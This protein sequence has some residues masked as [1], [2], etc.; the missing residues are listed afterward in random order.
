MKYGITLPYAEGSM[1]REEV[2]AFVRAADDHGFNSLWIPE[3]WTFDA[4]LLLTS[5]IE[6][7]SNMQL[8]TGIV[9]VYSRTPALLGQSA[10]TLDALSGGRAVLGL[11]A[12]GPQVVSGWHGMAYDRPVG[13]TREAVEIVRKVIARE[14]LVHDGDIFQLKMGL[15]IIN[16]PIR[17]ELPIVIASMGPNNVAMTAEVA[18]GWM[19]V[20]FSPSR[21]DDVWGEPLAEGKA[22]RHE[23]LG[24]LEVLPALPVAIIES[25]EERAIARMMAKAGLALY[26]GGMGSRKSNF[27][28]DLVCRY[29]YD[30]EAKVIQDLYLTGKAKEAMAEVPDALVDELTIIGDESEV[31]E[32]VAEFAAAGATEPVLQL[33]AA[34]QATRLRMLERFAVLT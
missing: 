18:D 2:E 26:V 6:H 22:K 33:L 4:F 12:S 25:E 7:T 15:K 8:A 32:R 34:D 31:K 11:G 20:L 27:Y 29:G 1:S 23:S 16:H 14:P 9:N 28:N 17:S 30:E 13:R 21:V 3:A 5:L 19:P 24:D 10:A